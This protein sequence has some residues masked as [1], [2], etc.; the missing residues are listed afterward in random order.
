MM[1]VLMVLLFSRLSRFSVGAGD[2]RDDARV[3][4]I[5]VPSYAYERC[6]V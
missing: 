4:M 1:A 3:G 6:V 2:G 5:G